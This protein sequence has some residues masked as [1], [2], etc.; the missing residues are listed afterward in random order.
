MA[1][2]KLTLLLDSFPSIRGAYF[3]LAFLRREIWVSLQ[4][5]G[6]SGSL[7]AAW[8][9]AP[10]YVSDAQLKAAAKH[11]PTGS[12]SGTSLAHGKWQALSQVSTPLLFLPPSQ[13]SAAFP[14]K[15]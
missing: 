2:R 7:K 12:A 1:S 10:E 13:P 3:S 8:L 6:T 14:I 15:S 11:S 4:V 5:P 9:P